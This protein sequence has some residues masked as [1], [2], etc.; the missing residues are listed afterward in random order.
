MKTC[1]EEKNDKFGMYQRLMFIFGV[2]SGISVVFFF[3]QFGLDLTDFVES[4]FRVW[5]LLD[6]YWEF[7]Y[8]VIT[9]FIAFVWRPTEDNSRYAY[10]VLEGDGDVNMS[11]TTGKKTAKKTTANQTTPTPEKNN[12]EEKSANPEPSSPRGESSSSSL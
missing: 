11:K 5:W 8:L 9:T 1:R 12:D 3:V 4:S 10:E 6:T 2:I 7:I